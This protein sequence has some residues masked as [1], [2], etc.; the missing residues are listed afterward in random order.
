MAQEYYSFLPLNKERFFKDM[1]V[2]E[3]QPSYLLYGQKQK[4]AIKLPLKHIILSIML[5]L[6]IQ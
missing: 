4:W 3:F 6:I 5:S 1:K 2:F